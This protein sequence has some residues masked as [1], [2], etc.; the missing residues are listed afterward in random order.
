[1]SRVISFVISLAVFAIF[2][3]VV[4]AADVRSAKVRVKL[5][6]KTVV[7]T[8]RQ[9]RSK[10][11][12][13]YRAYSKAVQAAGSFQSKGRQVLPAGCVRMPR[14][15]TCHAGRYWCAVGKPNTEW[16]FRCGRRRN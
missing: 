16:R 15:L 5:D 4:N 9:L 3:S 7:M 10:N 12:E 11:P 8:G 6:G 14:F 1:M 2:S 13:I